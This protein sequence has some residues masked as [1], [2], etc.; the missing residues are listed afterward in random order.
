M[1]RNIFRL[2]I[3]LSITAA[4]LSACSTYVPKVKITIQDS[5]IEETN[6]SLSQDSTGDALDTSTPESG[7][8]TSESTDTSLMDQWGQLTSGNNINLTDAAN[9][10]KQ[11]IDS[12]N[13]ENLSTILLCFEKLQVKELKSL[14]EK[15]YPEDIQKAFTVASSD[16]LD[17]NNADQLKNATLKALVKDTKYQGYKVEQAEG[18]FYPVIDYT[19]YNDFIKNAAPDITAY[20]TIMAVE[21]DKVY[22]KDAALV[23][24]WDEVVKRALSQEEFLNKYPDSQKAGDITALYKTYEF[25][26][27]YGTNNTPLFDYQTQVFNKDAKTAYLKA[28][29]ED[30]KSTY[31]KELK[32]FMDALQKSSYK[33]T[34]T[35]DSY[36]KNITITDETQSN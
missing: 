27:M 28:T 36:R 18:M 33:L 26:T 4:V 19:F 7:S 5:Q 8:T 10:L 11:N 17:V 31:L 24:G 3:L 21:S 35:V 14:E 20:F 15:Y 13:T 22:A 30:N 29:K 12:F 25:I 23:I 1:N 16:K 9:F 6:K 2:S 34:K 32:G